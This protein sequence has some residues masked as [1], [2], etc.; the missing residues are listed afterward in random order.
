M[1]IT[2]LVFSIWAQNFS[3]YDKFYGS[4]GALLMLMLLVFI[5]SLILLIGYELIVS[6]SHLKKE[7]AER[8]EIDKASG[9]K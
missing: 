3:N 2:T 4:I 9:R 1:I 6:I 7:A 8:A 5:N